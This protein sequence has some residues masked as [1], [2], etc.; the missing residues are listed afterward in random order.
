MTTIDTDNEYSTMINVFTANE[1]DEQR[2]LVD[3]LTEFV[4]ETVPGAPGFVSA[5]VHRSVD[6]IH[7]VNYAQWES[8]EAAE[9]FGAETSVVAAFFEDVAAIADSEYY[10]YEVVSVVSAGGTGL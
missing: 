2:R 1:I 4:G 10:P 5:S 3:L 6:G 9:R 7:V 8:V